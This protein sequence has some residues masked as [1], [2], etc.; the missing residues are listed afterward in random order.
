MLGTDLKRQGACL[1]G[2]RG[3]DQR[4]QGQY[5]VAGRW[6]VGTLACRA[7]G[8]VMSRARLHLSW[9]LRGERRHSRRDPARL[10]TG[11]TSCGT[12]SGEGRGS[13]GPCL[14]GLRPPPNLGSCSRQQ[15]AG[16]GCEKVFTSTGS[17]Q[18]RD[19]YTCQSLNMSPREGGCAPPKAKPCVLERHRHPES[20]M[21]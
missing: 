5:T 21:H 19:K 16:Q 9:A 8:A 18:S 3:R 1:Q 13:A 7:L 2:A 11:C 6:G 17:A 15:G 20:V 10:R 14:A 4:A 12:Q